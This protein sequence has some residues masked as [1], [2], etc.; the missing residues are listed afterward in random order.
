MGAEGF[1][2]HIDAITDRIIAAIP[3]AAGRAMEMIRAEV[4]RQTPIETGNLVGS[5]EVIPHEDGADIFIPGPYAR[6][7]HFGLDFHHNTGNALFLELPMMTKAEE[8]IQMIQDD[9]G[10]AMD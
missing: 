1:D 5:E 8:A 9:L 7:Q 2:I 4:A 10:K 3:E 6:R